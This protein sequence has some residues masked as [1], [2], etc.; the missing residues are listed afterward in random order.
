MDKELILSLK[1][2]INLGLEE[3]KIF[4]QNESALLLTFSDAQISYF[5]H[6]M[7]RFFGYQKEK[8][9]NAALDLTKKFY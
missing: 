4:S 9:Q 8:G 3:S 5:V 2:Q 1:R 6:Q 7:W